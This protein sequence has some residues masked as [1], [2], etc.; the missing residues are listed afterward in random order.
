MKSHRCWFSGSLSCRWCCLFGASQ[1][2]A[3]LSS[4]TPEHNRLGVWWPLQILRAEMFAWKPLRCRHE[5]P[6]LWPLLALHVK[7]VQCSISIATCWSIFPIST[8]DVDP[9]S[10]QEL[11]NRWSIGCP[12]PAASCKPLKLAHKELVLLSSPSTCTTTNE[13]LFERRNSVA[14]NGPPLLRD[15]GAKKPVKWW[16]RVFPNVLSKL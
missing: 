16:P 15:F 7:Q 6:F 14:S 12:S 10:K 4:F 2:S 13:V 8:K 11:P 5:C 9:S 3:R 1:F